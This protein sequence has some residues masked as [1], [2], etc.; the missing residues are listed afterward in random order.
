MHFTAFDSFLLLAEGQ[1][2]ATQVRG[3]QTGFWKRAF[4]RFFPEFCRVCEQPCF[5]IHV[6]RFFPPIGFLNFNWLAS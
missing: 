1:K 5:F 6:T 2:T 3:E 4:Q